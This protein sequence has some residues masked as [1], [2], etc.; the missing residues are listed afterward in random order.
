M[1]NDF[2]WTRMR[3]EDPTNEFMYQVPTVGGTMGKSHPEDVI[4]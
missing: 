1:N 2:F 3:N 4:E